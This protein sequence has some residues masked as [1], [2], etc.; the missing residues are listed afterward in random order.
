MNEFSSENTTLK[1]KIQSLKKLG[2]EKEYESG[3]VMNSMYTIKTKMNKN[4]EIEKEFTIQKQHAKTEDK[5][6]KSKS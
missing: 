3:K 5:I 4:E 2:Y 1:K 6:K